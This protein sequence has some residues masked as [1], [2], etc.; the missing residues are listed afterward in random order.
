[1]TIDSDESSGCRTGPGGL[2]WCTFS[3]TFPEGSAA[4][5]ASVAS[6]M[7]TLEQSPTR[8]AS[9]SPVDSK[10]VA[11]AEALIQIGG[12]SG[13]RLLLERAA[14]GEHPRADFLLAETF[15]L[16]ALSR[17]GIRGM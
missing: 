7:S 16:N 10:L 1:M 11:R 4:P 6:P 3:Q 12:I 13:A 15:D 17:L 8:T 14:L 5:T 9:I 2:K